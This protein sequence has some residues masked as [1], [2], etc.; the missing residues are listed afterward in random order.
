MNVT[1]SIGA[2][3]SLPVVA[4]PVCNEA[5]TIRHCLGAL[6]DQSFR[7]PFEVLLLL[8]NCTDGTEPIV[9]AMEPS[10]PFR[11]H[12][13]EFRLPPAQ[14]NA[15]SARRLAMDMAANFTQ[16]VLL[17][18]DADSYVGKN[19]VAA[20]LQAIASGADA[21]AGRAEI[22]PIDAAR[23]P[24]KM[25]EDEARAQLL[26]T[27]LDRIDWLL[28]P[29][30]A[31]PW[32]RHVQH[33]GASIAV[34]AECYRRVGGLPDV[35]LGEDRAFFRRLRRI[36]AR[37]RHAPEV[38][39]TVSGR[40]V[41]RAK[42]G[43]A[44]TMRR[45]ITEADPWLDD[46]TEAAADRANR[47][48]ARSGARS[49]WADRA[50]G[51]RLMQL[52]AS[53]EISVGTARASLR[54]ETFGAAWAD[55]EQRSRRLR[56]ERVPALRLESELQA[57]LQILDQITPAPPAPWQVVASGWADTS[58]SPNPFSA[59]QQAASLNASSAAG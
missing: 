53:L 35:A 2:L 48:A 14:A 24:V 32:P 50:D 46:Y 59:N 19:W 13:A 55:L 1:T 39:V 36:D 6:S 56:H 31:D 3:G 12:V 5:E 10:L 27:L 30:P 41:G 29:D 47:A 58:L 22:D 54:A 42:D 4:I 11:L 44:D 49:L 37:I 7:D 17:T 33:S 16:G 21:V 9:R 40:L 34:T 8:N 25:L 20:N 43:M 15:G 57:A 52:A 26:V 51:P 38:V 28:D 45:R 23:L 18:T